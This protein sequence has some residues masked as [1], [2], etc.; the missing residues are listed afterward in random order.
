VGTPH[1]A[2]RRARRI[3]ARFGARWLGAQLRTLVT[4]RAVQ[5]V[6]GAVLAPAALAALSS[7]FREP[8]ERAK[9]FSIYGAI[10]ASVPRS[11]CSWAAR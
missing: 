6:F 1:V 4:A 10:G 2:L 9:A 8:Q 5:G 7:T 11:G 3:R